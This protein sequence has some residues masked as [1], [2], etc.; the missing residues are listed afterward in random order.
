MDSRKRYIKMVIRHAAIYILAF[1]VTAF[2]LGL[3]INI[4]N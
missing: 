4:G 3:N 2:V 1:S